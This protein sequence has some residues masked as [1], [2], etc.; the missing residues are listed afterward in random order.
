M[1][2]IWIWYWNFAQGSS[3]QVSMGFFPRL[4]PL[5]EEVSLSFTTC[6]MGWFKTK[7]F[8]LWELKPEGHHPKRFCPS[9]AG[10][11]GI[12]TKMGLFQIQSRR[13][14]CHLP[15]LP[16]PFAGFCLPKKKQH[17]PTVFSISDRCLTT[18]TCHEGCLE[19]E[20]C[21]YSSFSWRL[22]WLWDQTALVTWYGKWKMDEMFDALRCKNR[23]FP[24]KTLP[25][26]WFHCLAASGCCPCPRNLN[27]CNTYSPYLSLH[28]V[29]MLNA[30]TQK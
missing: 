8:A 30:I 5:N 22:I 4:L 7:L 27:L 2:S 11:R 12:I 26:S 3:F 16:G 10:M 9:R 25:T 23:T 14:I 13:M 6:Q 1:W 15:I 18:C 21:G 29:V 17:T 28:F 24:R 19:Q 20:G